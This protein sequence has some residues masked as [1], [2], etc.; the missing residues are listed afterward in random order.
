LNSIFDNDND[1][2]N[3]DMPPRT[4]DGGASGWRETRT[5]SAAK[6]NG[7]PARHPKWRETQQ[8]FVAPTV[9]PGMT[10]LRMVRNEK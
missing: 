7:S 9:S 5:S 2:E 3:L 10:T 4:A 6:S 8:G 1:V